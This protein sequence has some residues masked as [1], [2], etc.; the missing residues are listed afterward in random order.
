MSSVKDSFEIADPRQAFK[1]FYEQHSIPTTERRGMKLTHPRSKVMR[2]IESDQDLREKFSKFWLKNQFEINAT[3]TE[4]EARGIEKA[5]VDQMKEEKAIDANVAQNATPLVFDPEILGIYKPNAPLVDRL[6]Q[7]GQEGYTAV[8]NRIDSRDDAI[9]W[10]DEADSMNLLDNSESDISLAKAKRDMKIWVDKVSVADFSQ[11]AMSHYAN[12]RD[13]TLGERIAVHAQEKEQTVL[14][15]DPSQGLTDGSPGDE[16]A[17]EGLATVAAAAGNQVDKSAVSLSESDA[18]LK[19]I[20]AE[21]YSMLQSEK[22]ILPNDL[23]IWTSWTLYD[24]L[25][26]E[27]NSFGRIELDAD[28]VN[29]GGTDMSIGPSVPVTPSHNIRAHTYDDGTNTY[30]AGSAGD[31]FIVNTRS[32]R[33]R[34]LAP[35]S[36]VPLGRRGLADEVAMFEYGTPIY[37]A[38]GEFSKHLSDYQI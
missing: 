16:N 22:N 17:P 30:S 34:N 10:T 4:L 6:T 15:A 31:V 24:E 1:N 38:E 8:Y 33:Y 35:L 12:L 32:M 21:I 28:R 20:K 26:N 18:L 3:G 23:E 7:E 25:D 36:T 9:G 29:Y 27:L 14:Y 2:A 19:D 13:T 11:R 5:T 37:R